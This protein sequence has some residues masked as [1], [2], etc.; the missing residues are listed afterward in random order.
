MTLHAQRLIDRSSIQEK[1]E[2]VGEEANLKETGSEIT[3]NIFEDALRHKRLFTSQKN[4][5]T[6]VKFI[7]HKDRKKSETQ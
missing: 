5:G 6:N 3:I 1:R 4:V 7:R 2:R